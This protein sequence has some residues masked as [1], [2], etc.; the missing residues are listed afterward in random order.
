MKDYHYSLSVS[1]TQFWE[2]TNETPQEH[3]YA[4]RYKSPISLNKEEFPHL[5]SVYGPLWSFTDAA[6]SRARERKSSEKKPFFQLVNQVFILLYKV[7][8]RILELKY[9]WSST[10]HEFQ[11]VHKI[12]KVSIKVY[13]GNANGVLIK[14]VFKPRS[15]AFCNLTHKAAK[16]PHL[17]LRICKSSNNQS[18]T[19]SPNIIVYLCL[20]THKQSSPANI[21]KL[22]RSL[23]K[24]SHL[25]ARNLAHQ[26]LHH[27]RGVDTKSV[28]ANHVRY[29]SNHLWLKYHVN[30]FLFL[31]SYLVN[32]CFYT[33]FLSKSFYFI[34]NNSKQ[35]FFVK[36]TLPCWVNI[37][38][39]NN[40]NIF[41]KVTTKD[42]QL[43]KLS[44]TCST[45]INLSSVYVNPNFLCKYK[46][47]HTWFQTAAIVW[48][49]PWKPKFSAG[50]LEFLYII[51]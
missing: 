14:D 7:E 43:L 23:T 34:C 3:Q 10:W 29:K 44:K 5:L 28:S 46:D 42:K 20:N 51:H 27:D 49:L 30:E 2:K 11:Q 19:L 22:S 41:V 31:S 8:N 12:S 47:S 36:C 1:S 33:F 16:I 39:G 13:L 17:R 24:L 48:F 38:D 45:L 26:E 35:V 32:F 50:I 6:K 9:P 40:I 21:R 37:F 25:K 18:L 4:Y 15:I